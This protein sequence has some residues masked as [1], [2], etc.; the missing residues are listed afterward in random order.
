MLVPIRSFDTE[1]R[2]VG[3]ITGN[4]SFGQIAQRD[5]LQINPRRVSSD[6]TI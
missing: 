5:T 1:A 6:L 2:Q 4:I 3:P